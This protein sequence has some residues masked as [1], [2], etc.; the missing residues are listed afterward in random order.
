M[1][2]LTDALGNPLGQSR[3]CKIPGRWESRGASKLEPGDSSLMYTSNVCA[4]EHLTGPDLVE[5]YQTYYVKSTTKNLNCMGHA[6][7]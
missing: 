3:L 7:A 2:I 1:K 4:Q 5:V 6:K